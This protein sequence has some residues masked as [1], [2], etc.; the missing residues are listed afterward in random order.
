MKT[1]SK[2][3]MMYFNMKVVKMLEQ[4]KKHIEEGLSVM[5]FILQNTNHLHKQK[6]FRKWHRLNNDVKRI[7]LTS[8][9]PNNT[10]YNL[11]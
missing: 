10:L 7:L 6:R 3:I 5:H 11:Q 8:S 4:N 9:K 2:L 1:L